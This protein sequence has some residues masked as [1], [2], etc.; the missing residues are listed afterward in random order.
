MEN[1]IYKHDKKKDEGARWTCRRRADFPAFSIC[2]K[3]T[4]SILYFLSIPNL[5]FRIVT[6]ELY[7]NDT[8][9]CQL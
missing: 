7:Y 5:N 6:F 4:L 8:I 1:K 3:F 9:K 2:V